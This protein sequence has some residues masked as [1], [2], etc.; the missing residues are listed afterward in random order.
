[1]GNIQGTLFGLFAV[2][3]TA[4]GLNAQS[5]C[6]SAIPSAQAFLRAE[7]LTEQVGDLSI[8]CTGPGGSANVQIFL[9]PAIPITSQNLSTGT[10]A[11]TE[12]LAVTTAGAVQGVID[13]AGT[14][15]TFSG[16]TIP[17]V[18]GGTTSILITNIRVNAS[19]IALGPTPPP[20]VKE[21]AFVSGVGVRP[22]VLPATTVAYVSQALGVQ[23]L[24]GVTATPPFGVPSTGAPG[25][26]PGCSTLTP[27][28]PSFYVKFGEATANAFKQRGSS[29]SNGSVGAWSSLN[30]ETGYVPAVW[31]NTPGAVNVANSATRVRIVLTNVPANVVAY[32]PTTPTTD[33]P[34]LGTL[35]LT[36][37]E[38]GPLSPFTPVIPNGNNNLPSGM[39][40][41][42]LALASNGGGTVEAVYEVAM[43][44]PAALETY[45]IPVYFAWIANTVVA[46]NLPIGVSVSFA[47]VGAASAPPA[48]VPAFVSAAST[49]AQTG[50]T[51]TSCMTSL[52]F[53]FVTNEQGFDTTLVIAN[54]SA[55]P[56]KNI[57]PQSGTCNLNFYGIGLPF[58]STNVLAPNG[59][60]T[61]GVYLAGQTYA[62]N[63]SD[64]AIGFQGYLIAVCNFQYAH[65]FAAIE[66]NLGL[67]SATSMG[68]TAVV[69][70]RTG[71]VVPDSGSN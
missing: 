40:S 27:A 29:F 48:L 71:S 47:P 38:T 9:S 6:S 35:A 10:T 26:I 57:T 45:T 32:F 2:V 17:A 28:F 53:P 61:G 64:V 24:T 63:V 30:S 20:A 4:G 42:G 36:G 16:L 14:S 69:L 23:S 66:S 56:S 33:T 67:P 13:P 21:I 58:P 70:N 59:T 18:G 8:I 46:N 7:G 65:G 41:P 1:M 22:A 37:S 19:T 3:L 68:Y 55:D 11:Y 49:V 34:N 62:F 31:P 12:A 44:S 60:G 43:Q 15:I 39:G 52:L 5:T 54:T 51:V 50:P 25:N